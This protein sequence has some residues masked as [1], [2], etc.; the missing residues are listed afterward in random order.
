MFSKFNAR[1][2]TRYLG[3]LDRLGIRTEPTA[4]VAMGT[5]AAVLVRAVK[6]VVVDMAVGVA[7]GE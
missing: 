1:V 2:R 6:A 3:T 7:E 4:P 5:A